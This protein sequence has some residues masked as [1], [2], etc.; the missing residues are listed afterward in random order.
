MLLIGVPRLKALHLL[1]QALAMAAVSCVQP[2]AP[3]VRPVSMRIGMPE[4]KQSN[5]AAAR[6]SVS[7]AQPDLVGSSRPL[8]GSPPVEGHDE[9]TKTDRDSSLT[10]PV[11][12][13][14]DPLE[15]EGSRTRAAGPVAGAVFDEQLQ[16]WNVGGRGQPDFISSRSNY[17]PGTRVRVDAAIRGAR[18]KAALAL[19]NRIQ[20]GLRNRGY[21]PFRLCYE[22]AARER[23]SSGGKTWLRVTLG[24]NGSVLGARVLRTDLSDRSI[25]A[26]HAKAARRL[27]LDPTRWRRIDAEVLV[28]VWPGDV[29]LLPLPRTTVTLLREQSPHDPAELERCAVGCFADARARDPMLWGRLAL[30]FRVDEQGHPLEIRE[31]QSQFGDAE[32]VVCVTTCLASFLEFPESSRQLPRFVAAWRLHPTA[33]N[34]AHGGEGPE[35][36]LAPSEPAHSESS[37]KQLAPHAA[38][39]S[40]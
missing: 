16:T 22:D 24:A 18:S 33:A 8:L 17:H 7:A 10:P 11:K 5:P 39:E 3:S 27:R 12:V 37:Q 38:T 15:V 31:Y 20:A 34:T 25:A 2:L 26:C 1:V 32:A 21:W 13:T 9:P 23:P 40:E 29:P 35:S 19:A 4:D 36:E 6:D 14:T 30:S 28:S